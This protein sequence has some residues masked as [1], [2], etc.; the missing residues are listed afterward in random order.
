MPQSADAS[1]IEIPKGFEFIIAQRK[2][3]PDLWALFRNR[4]GVELIQSWKMEPL[5]KDA[6]DLIRMAIKCDFPA[7]HVRIGGETALPQFIVQ[8][9]H[10]IHDPASASSSR[11]V[12]PS[13]ACTPSIGK[14]LAETRAAGSPSGSPA[15]VRL[16][17]MPPNRAICS[18]ERT[19]LRHSRKLH[20]VDG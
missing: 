12:R 17:V 2:G 3:F 15:P 1:V 8:N 6:D 13:W 14:W 20:A 10:L 19:L 4:H 18:N 16:K 9:N 11:K 5:L 7:D